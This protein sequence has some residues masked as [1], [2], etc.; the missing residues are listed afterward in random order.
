MK[1]KTTRKAIVN[2]STNIR[3]AG[4]CDLQALLRN[5]EPFAYTTGVYGWNFDAYDVYGI[6]ICTGYRNMPGKRLEG[7]EEYE[8]KAKAIWSDHEHYRGAD[9][10]ERQK[11]DVEKLLEEFCERNLGRTMNQEE[12]Q[13]NEE[14]FE[15]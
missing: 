12:S 5:H 11:A 7:I 4:Y 1:V 10:Y 6:T 3:C 15:R 2:G 8:D 14:E 9:G 13:E